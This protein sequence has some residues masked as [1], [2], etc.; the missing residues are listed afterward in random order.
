MT[1]HPRKIRYSSSN[2]IHDIIGFICNYFF[3]YH[4]PGPEYIVETHNYQFQPEETQMIEPIPIA[5][6]HIQ[7]LVE[8]LVRHEPR[9]LSPTFSNFSNDYKPLSLPPITVKVP[10][11]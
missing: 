5:L 1:K 4:D 10:D 2:C 11:Q 6:V 7:I 9:A 3:S 8:S